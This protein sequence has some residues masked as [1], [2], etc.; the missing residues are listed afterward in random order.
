MKLEPIGVAKN[1]EKKHFGG[2][3]EIVTDIVINEKYKKR[4]K[5]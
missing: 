2:W 1:Q 5:V 3:G 4:L